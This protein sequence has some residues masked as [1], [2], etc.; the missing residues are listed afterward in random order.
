MKSRIFNPLLITIVIVTGIHGIGKAQTTTAEQQKDMEA[1]L[2]QM[3]LKLQNMQ[4]KIDSMKRVDSLRLKERVVVGYGSNLYTTPR[5]MKVTPRTPTTARTP[6]TLTVPA[7]PMKSLE[8][9]AFNKSFSQAFAKSLN[10]NFDA[11]DKKL[12]E[13]VKSGEVKE[14]NKSFSKSYTI[15]RDDKL[16]IDNKWGKVTVNTWNKN[17]FKV[18]A[19]I[20]ADAMETDEAQK[21][22]DAVKIDDSKDGSAVTFTTKVES[23]DG[24]NSWGWGTNN[25]KPFVRK[26]FIN[27][28]I[29]M[30]AKNPLQITNRFGGVELPDFDGKVTVNSS[31]GNFTAKKLGNTA[32]EITS[33]NG[34]TTIESLNG[35]QLK[36]Q[37]G[38]LDLG[39]AENLTVDAN[40]SAVKIGKIK[41]GAT[42]NVK[43]GPGVQISDLDKNVKNLNVTTYIA[44]LEVNFN[45]SQNFDFDVT[46]HNN[47][48]DYGNHDV[49][50]TSQSPD[51]TRRYSATKTYKGH[52][53]KGN[54]DKLITIKSNYGP[55]K[56]N[57]Q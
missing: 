4:V 5:A 39:T 22:L 12:E 14:V 31:F 3:E 32:N 49:T 13:R 33:R 37:Y 19:Q 7:T 41:S 57:L 26:V 1:R 52:L 10:L 48:F 21:L 24:N 45:N 23:T 11:S 30:P 15:D 20:R 16:V 56:F 18:E 51:D 47:S 40:I 6:M 55:V 50:V 53:G 28:T 38:S 27:Y 44:P 42:L 8:P 54:P 29:Y 2:K 17:E 46:V 35:G 25:G 34:A 9:L 43:Y 36:V